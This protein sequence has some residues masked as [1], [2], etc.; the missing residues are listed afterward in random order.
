[1]IP[2][3]FSTSP[4]LSRWTMVESDIARPAYLVPVG[5]GS[6][7]AH[8][9]PQRAAD[10]PRDVPGVIPHDERGE[11]QDAVAAEGEIVVAVHVSPVLNGV[12]VIDAVHLD[13]EPGGL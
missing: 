7:S 12:Y 6:R 11:A 4:C 1:M 9:R 10:L 3:G 13:D 2:A 8:V 5:Q